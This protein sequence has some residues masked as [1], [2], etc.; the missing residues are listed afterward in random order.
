MINPT[1][2]MAADQLSLV[3]DI[4]FGFAVSDEGDLEQLPDILSELGNYDHT[5]QCNNHTSRVQTVSNI[6]KL[7]SM[8]L[9]RQLIGVASLRQERVKDHP[10]SMLTAFPTQ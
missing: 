9:A 2:E 6:I 1:S 7:I 8:L 3:V 10:V 5:I 4:Y